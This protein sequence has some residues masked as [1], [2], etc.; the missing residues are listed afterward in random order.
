MVIVA[1]HVLDALIGDQAWTVFPAWQTPLDC[2]N[3]R[4]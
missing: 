3:V 2:A 4:E 1:A